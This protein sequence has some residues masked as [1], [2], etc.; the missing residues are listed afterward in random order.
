ML[1]DFSEKFGREDIF[2][3]TIGNDS[4]HQDSNNNSVRTTNFTTSKNLVVRRKMFPHRNFHK[5]AW[6]YPDGKTHNQTDCIL[7]D[8]KWCSFILN[9][10]YFCGANSDTDHYLVVAN[11]GERLTM[12][13]QETQK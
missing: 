10:R 5:H 4:L 1:R 12:S 3:P 7:T 13:E 2:R 11:A 8:R 6:T 9:V